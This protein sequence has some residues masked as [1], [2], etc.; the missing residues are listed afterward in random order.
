[1]MNL[2]RWIGLA[3][4][5]G[6]A[7]GPPTAAGEPPIPIVDFVR[8]G[9]FSQPRLSPNGKFLAMAVKTQIEERDAQLITVYD[10]ASLKAISSIRMPAFEVPLVFQ[11][12]SDTRL[13][14]AKGRDLGSLEQ[15][16][17]TGEILA[18][19]LDGT[20]QEYLYGYERF[21]R[22]RRGATEGADYGSGFIHGMPD[23]R[24][25]H[26]FLRTHEWRQS[27]RSFLYDVDAR[28][29]VRSLVAEIDQPD[30]EF[31]LQRDGQPRF[32]FGVNENARHV[33]FRRDT[34]TSEW[35]LMDA[36]VVGRGFWPLVFT[37]DDRAFYATFSDR[38]GPRVLVRQ[39]YDTGERTTLASDKVGDINL[40]Q[41]GPRPS[42][43]FAVGTRVGI[44]V[45]RYL[46]EGLPEARLHKLLS[47]QFPGRHV[48]FLDFSADGNKLL[49]AVRSDREPGEFYLFD[50]ATRRAEMLLAVRPWIDPA[51]MAEHK[52]IQFTARDG[53]ELHG[54]LTLPRTRGE[55]PLP[56]VLLPH[57][58]PH[59]VSDD[60]FFDA[61]AQFLANRGY[62]VIQINYRGS[63][64]R[65]LNFERAGY[66]E[67]GG[68]IQNDL[69][70]GVRWAIAQGHADPARVCVYGRSFGAYSAMMSVIREPDLFKCAI[71][72]AGVY[73]LSM[74]Y[75]EDATKRSKRRHSYLSEVI[76]QDAGVLEQNSP[77]RLADRIKVPVFLAHGEKDQV[78][79]LE[80]AEAM[81]A[82][83]TRAGKAHEWM[84]VAK[85]GHGFFAEKNRIALYEKLEAFLARH[86]AP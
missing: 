1:M 69:I 67:W 24:N 37:P 10:V 81:R 41:W 18:T 45:L 34:K 39:V 2:P 72:Y 26:F 60:W 3:L 64:G 68:K 73:D 28:T 27:N 25:G 65:G 78:T 75:T 63:G 38:G 30:L 20:N 33:V 70:D 51:R 23:Q 80:Q 66:R 42:Q 53:L 7:A 6:I 17:R 84:V 61:D 9:Q 4:G 44:P 54:Y 77:S 86:L 83:L 57:G 82:A 13:I 49:F 15:P 22:A 40:I 62:A 55:K 43:P 47:A 56:L 76:G 12:V 21:Q 8:A 85:E 19:D 35:R 74:I 16:V 71:G 58:G 52:P 5:L 32:A 59:R 14:V 36:S 48:S 31:L 46:D 79:P 11:W 29:G 50:Y